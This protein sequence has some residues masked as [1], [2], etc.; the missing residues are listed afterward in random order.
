[1]GHEETGQDLCYLEASKV[2]TPL[3]DLA[4]VELCGPDDATVGTVDG[5]LID[6]RDRRVRYF[7][8][9]TPGWLRKRRFLL[10][11][12][13]AIRLERGRRALRL[14]DEAELSTEFDSRSARPMTDDDLLTALFATRA[15]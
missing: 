1:M 7:V 10:E 14:E 6:P 13:T 3:G 9:E 8:V 15:A 12:D 11:G 2:V 4:D 5:V